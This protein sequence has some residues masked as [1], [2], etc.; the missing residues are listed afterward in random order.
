MRGC[1]RWSW[2]W[3]VSAFLLV[4]RVSQSS[5]LDT[6]PRTFDGA[7]R[8]GLQPLSQLVQ[9]QPRER[10][11]VVSPV[12]VQLVLSMA[13]AGTEEATAEAMVS[14]LGWGGTSRQQL[15]ELQ[16]ALQTSL[17]SPGSDIVLRI[18]NAV[19]VDEAAKLQPAYSH[20]VEQQFGSEVFSRPFHGS[21]I[22]GEIS[23]WVDQQTLGR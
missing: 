2:W 1:V 22:T 23:H 19:W 14:T 12:S 3:F 21:G 11:F 5:N 17:K 4:L 10:N 6:T 15:L 7:N 8:F 9:E 20:A 13:Y 16:S 18:A